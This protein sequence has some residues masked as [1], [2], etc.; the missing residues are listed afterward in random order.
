MPNIDLLTKI[1]VTELWHNYSLA[2]YE[3]L[4]CLNLLAGRS[5]NVFSHCPIS[6]WLLREMAATRFDLEN[7]VIY[8][9]LAM[10]V[11]GLSS[12]RIAADRAFLNS[13]PDCNETCQ[14]IDHYL[15]PGQVMRYLMRCEP[16]KSQQ[17]EDQ[18]SSFASIAALCNQL[19]SSSG[20]ARES[21]PKFF[22][23]ASVHQN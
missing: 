10:S 15:P 6:P 21:I 8:R 3:W 17:I 18:T 20:E 23:F 12:V 14:F 22:T 2:N 19:R 13:A 5:F 11:T 16:F 1:K 4:Y 9:E 7:P